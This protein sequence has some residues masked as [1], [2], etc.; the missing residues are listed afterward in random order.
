MN[1]MF[2]CSQIVPKSSSIN[3][4]ASAKTSVDQLRSDDATSHHSADKV[5]LVCEK[6]VNKVAVYNISLT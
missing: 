4:L 1:F 3:R 2:L 6:L 5:W